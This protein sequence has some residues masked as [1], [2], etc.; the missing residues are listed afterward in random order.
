MQPNATDYFRHSVVVMSFEML[1]DTPWGE[2]LATTPLRSTAEGVICPT[3]SGICIHMQ[4]APRQQ[5][6]MKRK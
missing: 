5:S 4:V 1:V 3:G 2:T 6:G